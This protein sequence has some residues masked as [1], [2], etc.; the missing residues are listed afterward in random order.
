MNQTRKPNQTHKPFQEKIRR[1][2]ESH[3]QED[4]DLT[5]GDWK[6]I[7]MRFTQTAVKKAPPAVQAAWSQLRCKGP[8]VGRCA[9][10]R[11]MLKAWLIDPVHGDIFGQFLNSKQVL[12]T[13]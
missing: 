5:S 1:F 2:K 4:V 13:A 8:R 3:G 10:R 9:E 7:N 6:K 12:F 11:A